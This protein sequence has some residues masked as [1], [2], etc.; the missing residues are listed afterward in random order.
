MGL[1][2]SRAL[3][4]AACT[5]WLP[6]LA[7]I[8]SGMLSGCGHCA[9]N[10]WW[11][12]PTVPGVLAAALAGCD[13]AWF[14]VVGGTASL[15]LFALTSLLLRELPPKLGCAAQ[16]IVALGVAAESIGFAAALRA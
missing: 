3:V 7:P 8:V 13:D 4:R 15:L 9:T 2:W 10:Y 11:S 16:A 6:T 12:L 1:P 5:V 14:F